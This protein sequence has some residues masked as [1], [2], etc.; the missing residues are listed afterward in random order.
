M[1][2]FLVLLKD[3]IKL[4]LICAV[5][6]LLLKWYV[7]KRKPHFS[8]TVAKH[9]LTILLV[10]ATILIGIKVSEEALDG[11]SGPTDKAILL[12]IHRNIPQSWTSTFALITL[13]GSFSSLVTLS[14]L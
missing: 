10:L 3:A 6:F 5:L 14:T 13:S 4:A 8:D 1:H 12:F 7:A 9:R 11:D 2:V